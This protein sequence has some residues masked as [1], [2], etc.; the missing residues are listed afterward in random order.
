M[1]FKIL[2]A[3]DYIREHYVQMKPD[4]QVKD[5]FFDT[6]EGKEMKQM[7]KQAFSMEDV[8]GDIQYYTAYAYNRIPDVV[9]RNPRDASRN[10]YKVPGVSQVKAFEDGY[11]DYINQVN[12]DL[13]IP[14][15]G[16]ALKPLVGKSSL[17]SFR[18]VPVQVAVKDQTYWAIPTYSINYMWVR[19]SMRRFI[20]ADYRMIGK[21]ITRGEDAFVAEEVAYTT[22][23]NTNFKEVVAV[24]QEAMRHGQT[25]EDAVAWDYEANVLNPFVEGARIITLSLSWDER[26][27][28]TFPVNHPDKPWK[29]EEQKV[30][31]GLIKYFLE[32]PIYKVGHNDSFDVRLSKVLISPDLISQ[33]VLDTKVAYYLTISQEKEE[34]FGLKSLAYDFTDLGG[35]DQPLDDYKT[36]FL[37][38]GTTSFVKKVEKVRKGTY[39]LVDGDY[40]DWLTPE[41][42]VHSLEIANHLLDKFEKT[43]SIRNEQDG[44]NF[45]YSW[46]P[47]SALTRYASGDV[48][49]TRRINR[50]MYLDLIKGNDK[51]EVLYT[52]HYPEL[53]EALTTME[54]N[55]IQL[56]EEKLM[57]FSEEFDIEQNRVYEE[58]REDPIITRIENLKEEQYLEGLEEKGKKPAERDAEKYKM[59]TKYKDP[60]SRKFKPTAASDLALALYGMTGY[61]LPV[62]REFLKDKSFSALKSGE[63]TEDSVTWEDYKTDA[64]ALERVMFDHPEFTLGNQLANY[65]RI[66]KLRTTYTRGLLEKADKDAVLHT[67]FNYTGTNTG[68]LSSSSPNLQQLPKPI[69]NPHLFG[70]DQSIKSAFGPLKKLGHD[71]WVNIDFAAQELRVTAVLAQDTPLIKALLNGKDAHTETASMVFGVPEEEVTRDMRNMAKSTTFGLLYG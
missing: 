44:G 36:W 31:E 13:I 57:K 59:Y 22:Y 58:M 40:L 9:K 46:I 45:D 14:V 61:T 19:P 39:E 3:M 5:I 37:L 32:S 25:P 66:E 4:G 12:P 62:E 53:L 8:S 17:G 30:I 42:R 2:F 54:V 69:N 28:V 34:S 60:E 1:A 15:G 55:G 56:D 23:D 38:S 68:R 63:I 48:D 7:L 21:Y 27:G 29:P 47:Y 51:M 18:G 11:L 6:K 65:K 20:E 10:V 26:Q 71:A 50:K 64:K 49:V 52:E 16:L 43:T 33:K 41:E 35:Y 70:Y 67:G 24:F